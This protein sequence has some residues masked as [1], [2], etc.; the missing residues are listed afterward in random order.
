MVFAQDSILHLQLTKT[1][2]GTYANFY[3]D[4]MGNIFL[5][6]PSNQIKKINEEY[7]SIAI[8]NDVKQYGDVYSI[9]ASNPLKII[10]YYKDFTTV[11]VLDR[12]LN[13][14]NVI[15]LRKQNILQSKAVALSYDNNIWI[16][17][18]WDN[19]LKKMDDYGNLLSETADFR[20][21]FDD[22]H[23]PS[24]IIDCSRQLYL[25][26]EKSGWIIFDYYGA[27]KHQY[28]F[29]GWKDV[30]VQNATLSGRDSNY[31]YFS[32]PAEF[33]FSKVRPDINIS[34][35]IKILFQNNIYYVL[36]KTGLEIYKAM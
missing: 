28:P 25:Y 2:A 11:V 33:Y 34:S 36:R 17:D 23:P 26:D 4:R 24:I 8:Y 16:Y 27:L 12:L 30:Q 32:R 19:K 3:I 22:I 6:N 10:V 1:I 7:D 14:L 9:D 15:D 5:L 21:L 31:I 35:A 13:V 18:E 20:M 29:I